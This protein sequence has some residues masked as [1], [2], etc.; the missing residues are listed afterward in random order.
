MGYIYYCKNLINNKGY[1]GQTTRTLEERKK[2]HLKHLENEKIIFHAAIKKYGKENFE[3]TI[4]GEYL[5]EDL[6]KYEEYWI[7]EK[8]THYQD[9]Y[10]YNMNYGGAINSGSEKNSKRIKSINLTTKEE[11]IYKSIHEAARQLNANVAH[12]SRICHG[13]PGNYSCKGYTFCFIDDNDKEIST[14]FTGDV[15]LKRKGISII[16]I[17]KNGKEHIFPSLRKAMEELKIDRHTIAKRI[18]DGKEF[19]GYTFKRGD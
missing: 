6:D 12:I 18:E 16:A 14:N 19:K 15:S 7:K 3:W 11:K 9:G 10:G 1:V 2:E 17:D 13:E 8:N 4:L 5:N